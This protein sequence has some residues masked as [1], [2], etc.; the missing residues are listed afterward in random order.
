[1]ELS[2]CQPRSKP[3]VRQEGNLDH[4]RSAHRDTEEG[5]PSSERLV[6]AQ[7]FP[8]RPRERLCRHGEGEG[9]NHSASKGPLRIERPR[10][11][12]VVDAIVG[13]DLEARHVHHRA[14]ASA[15]A[16]L[17][18]MW[19]RPRRVITMVAARWR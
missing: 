17:W 13:A 4:E 19:R 7:P 12:E 10:L 1:V 16:D 15:E 8:P 3:P 5:R 9:G 2:Q 6:L 14:L 11:E 18:R